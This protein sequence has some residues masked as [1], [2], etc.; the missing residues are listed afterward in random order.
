MYIRNYNG[1]LVFLNEAKYSDERDLY[2]AIW[3]IKFKKKIT[4]EG[5]KKDVLDYVTGNKKFV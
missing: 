3:R 1:K 2:I 5:N 4:K